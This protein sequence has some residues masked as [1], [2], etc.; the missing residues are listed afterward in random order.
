LITAAMR[1][2]VQ[3][4]AANC[5]EYCRLPQRAAPVAR[6][7]VE[8][9][10]P[11][12]H[13]GD[14]SFKNLALAC[15]RCNRYKGPNLSAIDPRTKRVVPLFNPRTQEWNAHFA[16]HGVAIVGRTAIG[17]ATARLL[18]MNAEDRLKVR[19]AL[20]DEDAFDT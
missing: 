1:R 19:A 2:R 7:Q 18:R 15:P 13:D 3:R 16:F 10:R 4:R 12:Q 17:R 6:F 11:R 5:C 9:I 20:R 8:H 14:D